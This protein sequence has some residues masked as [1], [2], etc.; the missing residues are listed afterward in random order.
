MSVG[1]SVMDANILNL[2]LVITSFTV[3]HKSNFVYL[4]CSF[5]P[6]LYTNRFHKM[7]QTI[8]WFLVIELSFG[9]WTWRACA[10][11]DSP[12]WRYVNISLLFS[13]SR[14]TNPLLLLFFFRIK[15]ISFFTH[16]YATS[17]S[18]S[19]NKNICIWH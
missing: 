8:W 14:L 18:M 9:A 15:L 7:S 17:I 3:L 16:E 1:H 4:L 19:K 2:G 10:A 11:A 5:F 13:V 6:L 12:V